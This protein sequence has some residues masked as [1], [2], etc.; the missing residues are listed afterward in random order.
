MVRE[1]TE[2]LEDAN[3]QL[4]EVSVTDGLTRIKN[5]RFFEEASHAE[6]QRAYREKT[7]LSVLMIDIDHFKKV[8]DTYGHQFGDLC[9]QRAAELVAGSLKRPPDMAARYGGEEF[10]VLLPNTSCEG[11]MTVAEQ[12]HRA[13]SNHEI[14]DGQ[15]S[16]TL[17]VSIGLAGEVP[18]DRDGRERLLKQAD[19]FLYVAKESGRN[20]IA[21]E[22]NTAPEA[23]ATVS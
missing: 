3:R 20:R 9:L 18:A 7:P 5:R 15:H 6:Y 14:S 10:V 19:D 23:L 11:A 1:R 21:W 16:L 22:G 12:I 2:A 4:Q 8:N 17:T 13:F